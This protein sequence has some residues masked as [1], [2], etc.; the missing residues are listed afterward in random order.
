[1]KKKLSLCIFILVLVT[2][3]STMTAKEKINKKSE[4]D[5]MAVRS[6][7]L[8]KQKETDLQ[9]KL[10]NS[11]AYAVANMKVTK[12]PMVG[13]GAGEGV[14]VIKNT[15]E[16]IYFT[17]KRFDIGGGWGAR[18]Y[19]ALMVISDQKI[20]DDWKDGKW[21]FEAGAEASA[22]SAV[23]EGKSDGEDKGFTM[24]ILPEAGASATATARV[25]KI[26]I[27]KDL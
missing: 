11:L 9:G 8:L 24:H 13:A 15:Q 19:K 20:L 7:Q 12:V 4:L 6:V 10:D 2:G 14:L 5:A 23:A 3:C 22:G 1:M 18:S 26:K 25:I 16:R 17:V 27:N 21:I